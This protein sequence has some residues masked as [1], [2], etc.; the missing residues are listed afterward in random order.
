M[1]WGDERET[2]LGQKQNIVLSLH[3]IEKS[4]ININGFVW[5]TDGQNDLW[6]SPIE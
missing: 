6:I 3:I 1:E 5:N 2:D 4:I